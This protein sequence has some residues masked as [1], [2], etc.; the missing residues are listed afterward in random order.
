M[1][2]P[3]LVALLLSLSLAACRQAPQP[4]APPVAPAAPAAPEASATAAPA[5]AKPGAELSVNGVDLGTSIGADGRIVTALENFTPN[6]TIIVAITI[7][8]AGATPINGTVTARWLDPEGVAFNEESRQQDFAGAQTVNFRVA[9]PK[10]FQPG[11]YKLEVALNGST[12]TTR[13]FTIH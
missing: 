5:D 2:R 11:N 10:G 12:V 13:E 7:T 8:N 9:Q 3:V 1:V 4:P 6:D